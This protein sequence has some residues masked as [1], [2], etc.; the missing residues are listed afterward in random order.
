M[1]TQPQRRRQRETKRK[2]LRGLT[3]SR[4]YAGRYFVRTL[5]GRGMHGAP[6]RPT[7]TL[8]QEENEVQILGPGA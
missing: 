7:S 5:T 2:T 8:A 1:F 6:F 3:A 4:N